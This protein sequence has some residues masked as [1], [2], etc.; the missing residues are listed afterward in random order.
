MIVRT[1]SLFGT[2]SGQNLL[3]PAILSNVTGTRQVNYAHPPPRSEH[4]CAYS[5]AVEWTPQEI[6]NRRLAKGWDQDQL[7]RELGVSRRAITNWETGAADPRG[8][9]RRA[10]DTVLGD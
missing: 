7:A 4:F 9:N 3:P 8:K 6:K 1:M 5:V 10:L 2:R